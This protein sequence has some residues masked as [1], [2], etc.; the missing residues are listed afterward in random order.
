MKAVVKYMSGDRI[1]GYYYIQIEGTD[2]VL[3]R[4][5]PEFPRTFDEDEEGKQKALAVAEEI[6]QSVLSHQGADGL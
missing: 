6:N 4:D 1:N 3:T 2:F 5:H